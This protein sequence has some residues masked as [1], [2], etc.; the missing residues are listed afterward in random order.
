MTI[1]TYRDPI[2]RETLG[3]VGQYGSTSY[4]T[5]GGQVQNFPSLDAADVWVR[6]QLELDS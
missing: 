1:T 3:A 6:G 2:S 4:G 5:A